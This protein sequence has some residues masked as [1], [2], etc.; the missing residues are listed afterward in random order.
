MVKL[1]YLKCKDMKSYTIYQIV[2][3]PYS[4]VVWNGL[5]VTFK[6]AWM[7]HSQWKNYRAL[8]A[9]KISLYIVASTLT[10]VYR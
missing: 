8:L 9:D 10:S 2:A 4:F 6:E 7:L 1:N 3:F 5:A